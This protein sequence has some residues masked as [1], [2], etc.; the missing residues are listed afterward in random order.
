VGGTH[1]KT[2]FRER[3]VF[4]HTVITSKRGFSAI[5]LSLIALF[6]SA[7]GG[8]ESSSDETTTPVPTVQNL[9]A[10]AGDGQVALSW[11]VLSGV[12]S[13][14]VYWNTSGGVS[15]SDNVAIATTNQFT[16][17]GLT[18]D[19][20]YYYRVAA[21]QSG[22]SGGL[23]TEVSATPATPTPATPMG[24]AWTTQVSGVTD[25]LAAIAWSGNRYVTVGGNGRILSSPDGITW[26]DRVSG[27]SEHL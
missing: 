14:S 21:T 17:S 9:Q 1:L 2:T 7:C 22:Q 26:N 8:G 4:R 13:Y 5:L 23:S 6:L 10:V 16:Q 3:L 25:G 12:D 24:I 20:T 27:T 18:N 19:T 15:D 11:D